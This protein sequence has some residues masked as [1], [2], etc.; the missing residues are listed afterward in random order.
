MSRAA[1]FTF[2]PGGRISG[3][4]FEWNIGGGRIDD[5][6]RAERAASRL[7]AEAAVSEFPYQIFRSSRL[8][9]K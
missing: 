4:R 7:F 8:I 3:G 2:A 5:D 1:R 9:T 6:A